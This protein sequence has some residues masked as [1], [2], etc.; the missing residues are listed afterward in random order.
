METRHD[1]RQV[2]PQERIQEW[3]F[4]IG[5]TRGS[6]SGKKGK[7]RFMSGQSPVGVTQL[8]NAWR[9]GDQAALNK[10]IPLIHDE[11]HRLAHIYMLREREGHTL[12]T[13]ALLNKA[14]MRLVDANQV[15][16]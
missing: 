14:Y 7:D 11:L 3:R 15:P 12:Q 8:L 16:V 9:S 10:L 6:S 13:T 5:Q 1:T 4:I 2:S